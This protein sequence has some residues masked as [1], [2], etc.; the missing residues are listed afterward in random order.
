L[1]SALEK[2]TETHAIDPPGNTEGT[3]V[4]FHLGVIGEDGCRP[5]RTSDGMVDI[6][7]GVREGKP[8]KIDPVPDSL[9]DR[10]KTRI[11]QGFLEFQLSAQD[12]G[13]L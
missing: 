3:L 6:V 2:S 9:M 7:A 1:S 5:A 11:T 10:G 4:N 12:E 13:D 8:G